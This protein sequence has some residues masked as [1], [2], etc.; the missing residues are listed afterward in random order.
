MSCVQLA[1]AISWPA[2]IP[3]SKV[4]GLSLISPW[5]TAPRSAFNGPV[6]PVVLAIGT[7]K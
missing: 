7:D 5:R 4:Q 3:L 1:F 6:L 2:D